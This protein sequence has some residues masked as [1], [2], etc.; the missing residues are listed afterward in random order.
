MKSLLEDGKEKLIA[1]L[2]SYDE[3]LSEIH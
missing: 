2:T 1:G 3:L